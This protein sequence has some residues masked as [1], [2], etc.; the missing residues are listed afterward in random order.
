MPVVEHGERAAVG[1]TD[2]RQ[3]LHV[4]PAI[5]AALGHIPPVVREGPNGSPSL[6]ASP[7]NRWRVSIRQVGYGNE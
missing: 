2:R 4:G 5:V 6:S 1:V 7:V 3:Q